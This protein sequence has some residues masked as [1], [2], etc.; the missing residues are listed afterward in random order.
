[1]DRGAWQAA[2]HRVTKNRTQ[3][4]TEHVCM[5][6]KR[7]SYGGVLVVISLHLKILTPWKE[8]YDQPR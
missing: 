4:K 7:M 2:D 5:H 1:M 3:L 8:S 6:S